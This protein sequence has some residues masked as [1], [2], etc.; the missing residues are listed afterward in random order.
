MAKDKILPINRMQ[1]ALIEANDWCTK[2]LDYRVGERF[3]IELSLATLLLLTELIDS[4]ERLEEKMEV[5]KE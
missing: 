4:I 2:N 3:K 1:R 5:E